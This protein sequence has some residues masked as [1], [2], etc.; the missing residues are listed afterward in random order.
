MCIQCAGYCIH[1][2]EGSIPTALLYPVVPTVLL[3]PLF[4]VLGLARPRRGW[5]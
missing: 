3:F 2:T 4:N 5:H 1:V